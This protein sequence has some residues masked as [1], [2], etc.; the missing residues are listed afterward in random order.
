MTRGA[1]ERG[2]V[3][4]ESLVSAML[5]LIVLA[6]MLPL[7]V[8]SRHL[9]A[10]V[11]RR[12]MLADAARLAAA[13][14]VRECRRAGFGLPAGSD[15]ISIAATD[16]SVVFGFTEDGYDGGNRVAEPVAA[17]AR[18]I[19]LV[20]IGRLRDGDE[21]V[22]SDRWGWSWDSTVTRVDRLTR[23][24]TLANAVP[25]STGP[26][27]GARVYRVVRHRW[28]ADGGGLRRDGQP[29]ADPPV[30]MR[31]A[32]E[33]RAAGE[34][35]WFDWSAG[36]VSDASPQDEQPTILVAGSLAVGGGGGQQ[37]VVRVPVST[38]LRQGAGTPR[39]PMP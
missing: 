6:A 25:R 31:L 10:G 16:G 17:G 3:L 20:S 39:S 9:L 8:G 34:A 24:I 19:V 13:R 27:D 14:M 7:I 32:G 1:T 38:H 4:L 2:S 23:R 33:S 15:G 36:T 11:S 37:P 29:L 5:V 21:I 12:A 28:M 30:T 26:A 18:E 35:R 22:V